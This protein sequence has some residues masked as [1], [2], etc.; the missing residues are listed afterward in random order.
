MAERITEPKRYHP[1]L[2]TLEPVTGVILAGGRGQRMGGIDK[3]LVP[4]N[5]HPM[6]GYVIDALTPQVQHLIIN[7]NRNLAQYRSFGHLVVSDTSE[8]FLGPLAGMETGLVA[9]RTDYVI[10]APCDCPF[11]SH[12]LVERLFYGLQE[13]AAEIAVAHDGERLHPVMALLHCSLQRSIR[14]F[15]DTGGRKIDQW[16]GKHHTTV[17]DFSDQPDM[18]FNI[19]RASD[20][21]SVEKTFKRCARDSPYV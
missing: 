16:F 14:E 4:L 6:V 9:A 7:A 11:I 20:R 13:S 12:H 18:F 10:T 15:L 1:T 17:V 5:G 3:G 8:G 19:N 2:K 21:V